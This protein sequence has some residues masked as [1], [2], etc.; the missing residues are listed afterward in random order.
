MLATCPRGFCVMGERCSKV[1][2]RALWKG[3]A[4]LGAE[5]FVGHSSP[6]DSSGHCSFES[7]S[8]AREKRYRSPGAGRR[9][10]CLPRLRYYYYLYKLPLYWEVVKLKVSLEDPSYK[11]PNLSLVGTE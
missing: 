4:M 6:R 7:F 9:S 8:N 2:C 3:A 10:I 5:D 11:F 1:G